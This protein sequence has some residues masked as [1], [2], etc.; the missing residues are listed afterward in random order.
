[1]TTMSCISWIF[2]ALCI[3]IRLL[4]IAKTSW[5]TTTTTTGAPPPLIMIK[6]LPTTATTTRFQQTSAKSN[7]DDGGGR[8][9]VKHSDD[10]SLKGTYTTTSSTS[11]SS[12]REMVGTWIGKTWIPPQHWRYFDAGELREMYQDKRVLWIGDSTARR[13]FA[14]MYGILNAT[15]ATTS[16]STSSSSSSED[17]HHV[18]TSAIDK[19][20]VIDVNRGGEQVE[21]CHK[22]NN[23]NNNNTTGTTPLYLYDLHPQLCRPA[24]GGRGSGEFSL[25]KANCFNEL[26]RI[27]QSE[28]AGT[29]NMTADVHVI[30]VAMGIWEVMRKQT[31]NRLDLVVVDNNNDNERKHARSPNRRLAETLDIAAKFATHTGIKIVW[32]TSGYAKPDTVA[33]VNMLNDRTMNVIDALVSNI[34]SDN[35]DSSGNSKSGGG[36]TDTSNNNNNNNIMYVNWGKAMHPRSFGPDA[37]SGDIAPHYAMEARLVLVQMITNRLYDHGFFV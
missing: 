36:I 10:E 12:P 13:S 17:H 31:C 24:P 14:T 5:T 3:L 25:I 18:S 4:F 6:L 32:R 30:I 21:F 2:L 11:S 8:N 26:E 20:S 34:D 37:L 15:T 1:M 23:Q 28:L 35:S 19:P 16:S 29:T 7:G 27:L 22:W 33:P 9:G